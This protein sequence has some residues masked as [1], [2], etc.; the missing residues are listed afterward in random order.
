[1][2]DCRQTGME[3]EPVVSNSP[4]KKA[5]RSALLI[6]FSG[7]DGSGKSTQ[8]E[9]LC[10]DLSSA[11]FSVLRLAFWDNVVALARWRAKFSHKFLKSEVGIGAPEKPVHRNDKNN[12][13]W[14]LT[15]FRYGLYFLD[16]LKLRTMV[17]KA[18]SRGH[19]FIVFDRYIFDQLATLPLNNSITR[20]YA[21]MILKIVPRPEIAYL[22]DAAPE[23]ARQR[24][25]EYP[26]EFLYLYRLAYLELR[27][28]AGLALIQPQSQDEVHAAIMN[29]LQ[30]SMRSVQEN[31]QTSL[32]SVPS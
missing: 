8:I 3:G 13:A 12:R 17:A 26:L 20:T 19:D 9:M 31:Q 28:M 2:D 24:K 29:Q 6:S 11:G 21:R 18:R 10:A 22:L 16:A 32:D 5:A 30:T 4:Q 23:V 7:M 1:V 25:P 27:R 14:Y 15:A